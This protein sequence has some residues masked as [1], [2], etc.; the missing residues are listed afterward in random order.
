[1]LRVEGISILEMLVLAA[2]TVLPEGN[3]NLVVAKSVCSHINWSNRPYSRRC[4]IHVR[5]MAKGEVLLIRTA[6]MEA[7]EQVRTHILNNWQ[8]FTTIYKG[9]AVKYT[10]LA[11]VMQLFGKC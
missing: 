10:T 4:S 8:D 7:A 3:V 2:I 5:P 9:T 1:M 6:T 11:R